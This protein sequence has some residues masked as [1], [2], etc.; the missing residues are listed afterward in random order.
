MEEQ[1]TAWRAER[2]VAEFIEDDEVEAQQTL[3]HLPGFVHGP[4]LLERIDPIDGGDVRLA[5]YRPADQTDIVGTVHEVAAVQFPDQG[6]VHLIGGKVK[7]SQILVG[8]E[9][10]RLDLVGDGPHLALG[11]LRLEQPVEDGHGGLEGWGALFDQFAHVLGHAVHLEGAQHHHDGSAGRIMTHGAVPCHEWRH[12]T[13]HWQAARA[14]DAGPG[15]GRSEM[16]PP[17]IR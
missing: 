7:A 15:V 1:R 9:T 17:P 11:Y 5:G 13:Q 10:G 14:A 6:F 12:S 4:F 8:R 2:Q 3:G 16:T